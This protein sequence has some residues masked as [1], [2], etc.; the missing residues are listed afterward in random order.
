MDS[1][2]GKSRLG[3]GPKIKDRGNRIRHGA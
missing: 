3:R 2:A 1:S